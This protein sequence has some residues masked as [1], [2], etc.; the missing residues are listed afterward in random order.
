M[1]EYTKIIMGTENTTVPQA[2]EENSV[3]DDLKSTAKE[4]GKSLLQEAIAAAKK[5]VSTGL[6][7]VTESVR[8]NG[9]KSFVATVG[10]AAGTDMSKLAA[11]AGNVGNDL[12]HG[13][14]VS[15]IAWGLFKQTPAYRIAMLAA[16]ALCLLI[17][18]IIVL[19]IVL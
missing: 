13:K 12:L 14:K 3:Q 17:V 1:I 5:N 16:L 10:K 9:A 2:L 7:S 6:E 19:I 11:T 4:L 18:L 8:Q 15:R